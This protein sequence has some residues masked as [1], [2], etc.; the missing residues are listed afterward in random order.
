MVNFFYLLKKYIAYLQ[1]TLCNFTYIKMFHYNHNKH[2]LFSLTY[3]SDITAP[4]IKAV[5]VKGNPSHVPPLNIANA[6]H[7]IIYDIGNNNRNK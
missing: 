5:P 2:R 4:I 1:K 7:A 3:W 6:D